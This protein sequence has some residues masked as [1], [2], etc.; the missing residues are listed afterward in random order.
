MNRNFPIRALL[1]LA[2]LFY[3]TASNAASDF[4]VL[5]SS[6]S[7]FKSAFNADSGKVRIVM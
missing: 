4:T 1:I 2:F 5:D 6:L 7:D 3:A